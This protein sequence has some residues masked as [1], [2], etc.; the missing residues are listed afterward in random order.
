MIQHACQLNGVNIV[1]FE[2]FEQQNMFIKAN[3]TSV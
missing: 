2:N 1:Q 3:T